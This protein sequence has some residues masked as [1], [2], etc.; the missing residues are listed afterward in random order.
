V[1]RSNSRADGIHSSTPVLLAVRKRSCSDSGLDEAG[2]VSSQVTWCS[3]EARIAYK[4]RSVDTN[5][6][7]GQLLVSKGFVVCQ[8]VSPDRLCRPT[9]CVVRQIVL[10]DR[11]CHPTDCVVQQL[12]CP[13]DCVVRQVALSNRLCCPTDCVVRPNFDV[14]CK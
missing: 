9:D 4:I 6:V 11:L 13:T 3:R 8:V 2:S 1:R 14:P 5:L 10:S 7:S 12:C